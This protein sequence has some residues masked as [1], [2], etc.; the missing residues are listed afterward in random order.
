MISPIG[1]LYN[2]W[3]TPDLQ[4]LDSSMLTFTP[5][6]SWLPFPPLYKYLLHPDASLCT[7]VFT[8][9][10][11]FVS[12][13]VYKRPTSCLRNSKQVL[14]CTNTSCRQT[15]PFPRLVNHDPRERPCTRNPLSSEQSSHGCDL[16]IRIATTRNIRTRFPKTTTSLEANLSTHEG[17]QTEKEYLLGGFQNLRLRQTL[18]L[19]FCHITC[20]INWNTEHEFLVAQW[21]S[22][23]VAWVL[24]KEA[25]E[26]FKQEEQ[27]T[28]R[29]LTS[30]Q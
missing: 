14:F 13:H 11:V 5:I 2:I 15:C 3:L 30:C 4:T 8:P 29:A 17:C 9:L 19:Q 25:L 21:D 10:F 16:A 28:T 18:Y 22:L 20:C 23:K 1:L 7:Y 27:G 12:C 24:L 26:W 6:A